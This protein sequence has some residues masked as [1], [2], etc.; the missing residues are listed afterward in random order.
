MP[1]VCLPVLRSVPPL[2]RGHWHGRPGRPLLVCAAAVAALAA[3]TPNNV[4]FQPGFE[5]ADTSVTAATCLY[6]YYGLLDTEERIRSSPL[7]YVG[8]AAPPFFV[9]NGDRDTL[10]PVASARH[11]AETL[12][13]TSSSPVVY[14]ELPGAQHSFDLFHSLGFEA[15]VDAIDALHRLD[16]LARSASRTCT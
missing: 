7:T 3:L 10:V 5:H 16:T 6:G 13:S 4:A 14:A 1:V 9:T 11:V 12:T 8:A 2:P 15:V